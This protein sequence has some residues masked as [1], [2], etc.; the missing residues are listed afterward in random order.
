MTGTSEEQKSKSHNGGAATF[1]VL[2]AATESQAHAWNNRQAQTC[3]AGAFLTVAQSFDQWI[4]NLW[5][6][7]GDGRCFVSPTQAMLVA[8]KTMA[9][10]S[11][12][13]LAP[14]SGLVKALVRCAREGVGTALFDR[15]V[16]RAAD[17]W[18]K[19]PEELETAFRDPAD[20]L[21]ALTPQETEFLVCIDA[22]GRELGARNL[23]ERG[24]AL[25]VLADRSSEV[26]PQPMTIG[27]LGCHPLTAQQR[28][29]FERCP[30][31]AL[32]RDGQESQAPPLS[33]V[34]GAAV[35]M[36]FPAG[37][38][39]QP[40]VVADVISD[41]RERC[42]AA[43]LVVASAD[44][45]ALFEKL[46]IAL[47]DEGVACAVTA[48]KPLASTDFARAYFAAMEVQKAAVPWNR[49]ALS[50]LLHSPLAA[51]R[52]GEVWQW[53]RK[54]RGDRIADQKEVLAAVGAAASAESDDAAFRPLVALLLRVAR[55]ELD[56][57]DA[58][59]DALCALRTSGASLIYVQEQLSAFHGLRDLLRG[60]QE[61]G[62]E[63]E[64]LMKK[65]ASSICIPISCEVAPQASAA[66][67][68]KA[69]C[70]PPVRF[71]DVHRAAQLP[72][73]SVDALMVCDLTTESAPLRDPSSAAD[74]LLEALGA[75]FAETALSLARREFSALLEVARK[76]VV[77][78]RCLNDVKADPYYPSAML[79]ELASAYGR[80][81]GDR[82]ATER[83]RRHG[84]PEAMLTEV[85]EGGEE[86]LVQDVRPCLGCAKPAVQ[87]VARPDIARLD[88]IE[89]LAPHSQDQLHPQAPRLSA[90]QIQNYLDCP[91]K[92]F[93]SN[94]LGATSL[95][96]ELGPR[97][98]GSF[99]HEVFQRFYDAFE[100][101][102]SFDNLAEAEAL[103]FGAE[104]TSGIFDQAMAAQYDRDAQGRP[105]PSRFAV[106]PGTTE[107]HEW[108]F[109]R[110]RVRQWLR[111]EAS[112]L[113]SFMPTA[114]ECRIQGALYQGC[115]INGV[116]DRI[117]I[118]GQGRAVVIDYK[119]ALGADYRGCAHGEYNP[120]GKVQS[121]IY[122]Q[123]LQ[124][125]GAVGILPVDASGRGARF[126]VPVNGRQAAE[127]ARLI[128]LS[129]VVGALYVSYN[130]G[131]AVVGAFDRRSLE[132]RDM[133]TLQGVKECGLPQEGQEALL[134]FKGLGDFTAERVAEAV[135]GVKAGRVAPRPASK[136]AC[137]HCPVLTCEARW[138]DGAHA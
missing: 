17:A 29:F 62:I 21:P 129:Q 19:G 122:A 2:V 38:H 10:H 37:K 118:D 96:E 108:S 53:D 81:S 18:R 85:Y 107:E 8:A 138:S 112:F 70:I 48:T 130:K 47:I 124:E 36:A 20:G 71:M 82:P 132:A 13:F 79:E 39:A 58:M 63:D 137:A 30:Q 94:R 103:M 90:S 54:V 131:N 16:R 93:V 45:L 14:T 127:C 28:H 43:S 104:G 44:P 56:C 42:A 133:P 88:A 3:A 123:I 91:Y 128:P 7:E 72:A 15:A 95:D 92:W 99:L 11:F 32:H 121:L 101:K 126:I 33:V 67:V 134:T 64:D 102:V 57:L 74:L 120:V 35:A 31:I 77:L 61:M 60:A 59:E 24:E 55:G 1:D 26:F 78:E 115:E 34:E 116:I 83:E 110:H 100:G 22:Y 75:G 80:Q 117:D 84:F 105:R 52:K 66:A 4:Q 106:L 113:P 25:N 114:F 135:A 69:G 41:L 109:L 89:R 97:E 98:A 87:T 40:Q 119:G 86:R 51:L 9:E 50:D 65:L 46:A 12:A 27:F 136:A 73:Q 76:N 5:E 49:D 68:G 111:F 6:L 125:A 23:I